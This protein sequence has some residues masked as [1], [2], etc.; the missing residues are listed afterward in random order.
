MADF[1][2]ITLS[3]LNNSLRDLPLDPGVLQPDHVLTSDLLKALQ[4][5]IVNRN[6]DPGGNW[7]FLI[8]TDV[9][10]DATIHYEN[11][12]IPLPQDSAYVLGTFP[13]REVIVNAGLTHKALDMARGMPGSWFAAQVRALVLRQQ[14]FDQMMNR[15]LALNGTGALARIVSVSLSGTTLTVTCDNTY[16]DTGI[17]NVARIQKGM[18]IEVYASDLTT[19]RDDS[20]G[21]TSWEVTGVTFGDRKNG[22]A[23]TGTFT[24]TTDS[25]HGFSDNDVVYAERAKSSAVSNPFFMGLLAWV[26]DGTHY[27]GA[28]F[29]VS[30]YG[31]LTRS[32]YESLMARIYDADDFASGGSAGTPDDW[33]LSTISTAFNDCLSGSG[34]DI[35]D[36]LLCESNLAMAITRR[37]KSEGGFNVTVNSGPALTGAETAVG[38]TFAGKFLAPTGALIPIVVC[39]TL[40]RNVLYG[41]KTSDL[42]WATLGGFNNWAP[43]LG[44]AA[45]AG[46]VWMMAPGGRKT[47]YEAPFGGYI[48]IVSKRCDRHFVIRDMLDNI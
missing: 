25:G 41:I 26:Q 7:Q 27:S 36:L 6:F 12:D 22:A 44:V 3:S 18:K 40:P 5:R 30:T 1:T 17:E 9:P 21:A 38:S 13:V 34:K 2:G 46:D 15:S 42:V 20:A 28:A 45:Q 8:E 48:Q 47:N 31:G 29:K 33:N 16:N 43:K 37:Q 4:G 14:N 23:T 35:P 19:K 10:M 39:N 32:S 11:A 24:I